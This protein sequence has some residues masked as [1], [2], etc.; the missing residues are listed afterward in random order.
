MCRNKT[1]RT[2][3]S[4]LNFPQTMKLYFAQT[5]PV[6]ARGVPA[7]RAAAKTE[8]AFQRCI[9]PACG[10][11]YG[12]AEVRVACQ[13]C[14]GLLDVVYNWDRA[15]P[16][17]SLGFFE[18]KWSRR[19]D[20]LCFSGVW[21]FHERLPFRQTTP[22]RRGDDRRGANAAAIW[23]PA[24]AR[25]GG[26]EPGRLFLQYEGMNPSGSFKDNGMSA[27][28]SPTPTCTIGGPKR[29]ACALSTGNTSASPVRPYI[30]RSVTTTADAEP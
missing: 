8:T 26:S 20:P 23:A 27:R 15:V 24:V 25:Y 5:V 3:H 17:A 9:S 22:T 21:R 29:A 2:A 16:P 1:G 19:D 13:A 28:R 6:L 18:S 4:D 30:A 14:G 12:I 7:I 10:A 11:T